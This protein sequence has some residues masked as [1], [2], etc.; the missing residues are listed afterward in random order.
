MTFLV[1]KFCSPH[2]NVG[3][4]E[5]KLC[6]TFVLWLNNTLLNFIFQHE[7]I[8]LWC[9][10]QSTSGRWTE[11]KKKSRIELDHETKFSISVDSV[12]LWSMC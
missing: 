11:A 10:D 5:K 1:S 4:W 12:Y 2:V 6:R 3:S 7:L 9:I 8:V